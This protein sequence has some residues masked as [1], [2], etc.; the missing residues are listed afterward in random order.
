LTRLE[1]LKEDLKRAEKRHADAVDRW[2]KK[3]N[4][5]R[6]PKPVEVDMIEAMICFEKY[7]ID[8]EVVSN[9]M[10]LLNR[11]YYYASSTGRWRVNGR[12]KWYWSKNVEDFVNKYVL[13]K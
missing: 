6:M 4:M 2:N 3:D 7:S 13:P 11:K 5:A 12:H 10:F 9:G 1:E 8:Y